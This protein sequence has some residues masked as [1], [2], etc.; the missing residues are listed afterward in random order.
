MLY[1]HQRKSLKWTENWC[2]QVLGMLLIFGKK[3]NLPNFTLFFSSFLRLYRS[4]E[5]VFV[6]YFRMY[7]CVFDIFRTK[8]QSERCFSF[9]LDEMD[10]SIFKFDRI[11]TFIYYLCYLIFLFFRMFDTPW[12]ATSSTFFSFWMKIE[13]QKEKM[14]KKEKKMVEFIGR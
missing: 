13:R 2:F 1:I 3:T 11:I 14:W 7:F 4:F 12:N 5:N 10:C 6:E 9:L 8:L